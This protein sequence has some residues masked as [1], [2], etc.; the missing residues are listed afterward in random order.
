MERTRLFTLITYLENDD[1]LSV[2]ASVNNIRHYAFIYHDKDISKDGTPVTPHTH[3]LLCLRNPTTCSAVR[4]WFPFKPNTF[5]EYIASDN[6]YNYLTHDGF[7]DKFNYPEEAILSDDLSY[8]QT[9]TL[10]DDKN[11]KVTNLILDILDNVPPF[12][13]L[14]RYGRDYVLNYSKYH[15]FALMVKTDASTRMADDAMNAIALEHLE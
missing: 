9:L 3:L 8:W 14:R 5:V 13:M 2:I 15:S 6:I 1:I 10:D 7:E 4:K 11:I 12:E